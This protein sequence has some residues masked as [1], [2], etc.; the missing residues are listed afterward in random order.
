MVTDVHLN[1]VFCR[2]GEEEETFQRN[3]SPE[4]QE[5]PQ[6]NKEKKSGGLVCQIK[7]VCYILH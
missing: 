4:A 1:E 5:I 6:D 7:S 3:V 2:E